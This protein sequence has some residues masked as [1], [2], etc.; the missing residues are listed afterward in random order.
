MARHVDALGSV[1]IAFLWWPAATAT[2]TRSN[3]WM[4]RRMTSS[5]PSVMGS[6]VP[7]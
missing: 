6:K 7:G 2:I 1:N 3:S 4:A 5:W